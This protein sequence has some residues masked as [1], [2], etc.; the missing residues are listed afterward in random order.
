MPAAEPVSPTV[1]LSEEQRL[2]VEHAGGPLIVLAG[3]GTGKTRVITARVA[4][5]VRERGADP[6]RV[7][8]VTFTNKAAGELRSRLQGL[9]GASAACRI[10]AGTMH[11]F[12]V[13]LLQRF[14]DVLGLPGEF[15]ILDEAQQRRL[16]RELIR[17]N[18]LYRASIG[19]GIDHAVEHGLRVAH[20]LVSAGLTPGGALA[21][22]DRLLAGLG[23][24]GS[25]EARARRAELSV[26]REGA[27]LARLMDAACL[28]RAT[29]R[30]DDL[31]TWPMMLL[32]RSETVAAIV[33]HECGHVVVDEFQDLNAT[34]IAWLSAL[35]PPRT[36]PDLCVVG[37]DDQ[38][39][40]AFRGADERAFDR[41]ESV[42]PGSRTVRLTTNYRSGGA[43]IDA[44]NAVIGRAG[45][46]FD[47]SKFGRPGPGAPEGSAVEVVR[48][49]SDMRVGETAAAMIRRRLDEDPGLDLSGIAVIART[50]T[51]LLRAGAALEA[52][53]VPYVS[54]VPDPSREDAGVRTVLAWAELAVDPTRTWA[55]RTVLTRAP[56]CVD[57]ATLATLEHRY[58]Q[59]RAWA[60]ANAGEN[61][62][63]PFLAWL[64]AHAPEDASDAFRRA[65]EVERE[66]A[67][68][69]CS[70]PADHA[71]M[72]VV[73]V[74]G[75]AHAEAL[76]ARERAARVRALVALI[77]F[78]RERLSRLEEPAGLREFLAYLD[79][80]PPGQKCFDRTPEDAVAGEEEAPDRPGVRLLTAHASKGLEFDT[81]YLLRCSGPHGFPKPR[82]DDPD[83]PE[84]VLDPDPQGRDL[85]ARRDDEERRVFFVALTRA[86]RR[87][88]ML[89]KIP[90]KP[91]G[92]NYPLEIIADLGAAVVEHDEADVGAPGLEDELTGVEIEAG[93]A[94]DR[95]AVLAAAKRAARRD[96][97]RALD[98]AER[99]T[100]PD[101]AVGE[102]LRRA[103]D[104]LAMIR[105]VE[106]TGVAPRWAAGAGL[107]AEAS[108]L[109]ERLRE[110]V[111]APGPGEGVR[112][113]M[114]L[115]YTAIK[116]YLDC[117]RCYYLA[118]VLGLPGE[119]S[120]ALSLGT[121]VHRTLQVYGKS[122]A[123]ADSEGRT[124]P[125]WEDLERETRRWLLRGWPREL[126]FDHG[127]LERGLAM[128]RVFHE[129][130]HPHDAHVL[131]VEHPF[132]FPFE[133]DGVTHTI[134][135]TID[136]IDQTGGGVRLIDYKTG[137]PTNK[138]LEP[139]D[140]DLQMG[141]Y[142]MA[143]PALGIEPGPGS[144][145]E[146]WLLSSGERGAVAVANLRLDK[147]RAAITKAVRGMAEGRWEQGRGCNG[148]CSFLDGPED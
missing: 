117:P 110:E 8:A 129:Q 84:G 16:A 93:V 87:A 41:F 2:A 32:E 121:A 62:P 133:V 103:A 38:S 45:Y 79:D 63:G 61:E 75:A 92:A 56:F 102:R 11:S 97:A 6:G 10:T 59:E 131:H 18:G 136:R 104:R 3:P 46:R 99:L 47:S 114:S 135:G 60:N 37:D 138:L 115:S 50:S 134:R 108:A 9:L 34:Q 109:A 112:G 42:W 96:A 64:S 120:T 57:G 147:V 143:L 26:A 90:K 111:Q 19:R 144:A 12:G 13:R 126:E 123:E 113:P 89:G 29:P 69:A 107:G 116:Q 43:V 31:I 65:A 1:A 100:E 70:L 7:L 146:Y 68:A 142:A 145:C 24:D 72:H 85:R 20:E 35:C 76:P 141:I 88:V 67:E 101:E 139:P 40:Y 33:R 66:L 118:F 15:E 25:P 122:W 4:H 44:S 77:R 105:H 124:L 83:L 54:S 78:A 55:A 125:G 73:R 30:F 48:M 81:V 5:L 52:M 21:R 36:R 71:L 91:T 23:S 140:D 49:G 22:I 82:A 132:S 28:D 137:N 106:R 94:A 119:S 128:A 80:L 14:G 58:R 95:A 98:E 53:G 27:E 130:L 51:E 86:K 39:I 17:A 148:G 127:L 74:S